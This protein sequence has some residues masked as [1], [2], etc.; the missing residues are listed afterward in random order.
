MTCAFVVW[1]YGAGWNI[2]KHLGHCMPK[3][4]SAAWLTDF[5]IM[6]ILVVT[7][8]NTNQRPVIWVVACHALTPRYRTVTQINLQQNL[9]RL[10]HGAFIVACSSFKWCWTNR[11]AVLHI[12]KSCFTIWSTAHWD[13]LICSADYLT[14]LLPYTVQLWPLSCHCRHSV[15]AAMHVS[16]WHFSTSECLYHLAAVQYGKVQ[17]SSASCS[18]VWNSNAVLVWRTFFFLG[19]GCTNAF[20]LRILLLLKCCHYS[21]V[22]MQN[23]CALLC[24]YTLIRG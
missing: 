23:P 6:C 20:P 3:W 10:S 15:C 13:I 1:P 19:G 14:C 24:V 11:A 16:T 8:D 7:V 9:F 2:Q 5:I 18:S 17:S 22:C 4:S 21:G 12:C